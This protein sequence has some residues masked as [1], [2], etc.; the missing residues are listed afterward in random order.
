MMS[1]DRLELIHLQQP[2]PGWLE[3]VKALP[4]GGGVKAVAVQ[5]L[6]EARAA[7]PAVRTVLRYVNDGMQAVDPADT[8]AVREQRARAWFNSFIDGTFLEGGTAGVPHWQAT[9]VISWWNEYYGWS[10][11]PAEKELWWRQER[12]AARIWRDEYRQ[13]PHSAKLGHIRLAIAATAVG[14]DIPWQ[15]AQTATMYDCIVDYHAYDKF[16]G[17]NVRD[18]LSWQYHTGR[19]AAMDAE[20]LAR[21]YKVEWYFG[22]W[23]PYAGVLEG[24]KHPTVLG[25]NFTNLVAALRTN[26]MEMRSTLAYQQGRI[27]ATPALFTTGGGAQW[28]YYNVDDAGQLLALAQLFAELWTPVAAPPPPPPP[29]PDEERQWEKVVWLVP[30][31]IGLADYLAVCE[32]AWAGRHEVAFS[33]DAAFD[34]PGKATSHQVLVWDAAGWGGEAELE[35]WVAKHYTFSPATV[36]AYKELPP[37][38]G[39]EGAFGFA[40]WPTDFQTVTQ[41][42]GANPDYYGQFGQ[43]G[44]EGLDIRAPHGSNIYAVA[45]GLVSDLR[46]AGDAGH[47]YGRFVRV[48]HA[49]GYE[50]TYGHLLSIEVA[51]GQAVEAGQVIGKA[52]NTGNIVSGASHLHLTLKKEGA[53]TPGYPARIVDPTPFALPWEPGWP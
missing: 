35:A 46:Q 51:L 42:F 2:V 24:W 21:G 5:W 39:P 38:P 53:Q 12:V 20:F 26:I 45:A 36:V 29:P 8:D 7:N 19:W 6:A 30:Q 41:R 28:Q 48:T 4:A 15:T 23:G 14:N 17:L 44:H 34:R 40:A 16:I 49:D 43:A 10:Q 37:A 50:T 1:I 33:A 31:E 47:A 25:G 22:E 18:P 11:T 32:E 9:D 27:W 52:D 13:G 3:A